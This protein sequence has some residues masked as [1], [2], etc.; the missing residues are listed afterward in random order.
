MKDKQV[1]GGA[2][3]LKTTAIVIFFSDKDDIHAA[4]ESI[5]VICTH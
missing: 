1:H 5:K 4:R 3:F 2:S